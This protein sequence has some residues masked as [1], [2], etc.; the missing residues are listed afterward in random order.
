[1]NVQMTISVT[2]LASLV[3][4]WQTANILQLNWHKN[5]NNKWQKLMTQI[6]CPE[7]AVDEKWSAFGTHQ[8]NPIYGLRTFQ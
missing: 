3:T 6:N 5:A 7:Q 8:H 1:M 2:N 4:M